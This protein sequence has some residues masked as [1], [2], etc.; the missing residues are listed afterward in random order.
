VTRYLA[1]ME[2]RLA[3]ERFTSRAPAEEVDKLRGKHT[4]ALAR[5]LRLDQRLRELESF[6]SES[7]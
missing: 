3:D 5:K 7:R 6:S 4:A 2:T 1:G